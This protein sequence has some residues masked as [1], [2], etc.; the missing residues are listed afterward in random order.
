[1]N[2]E[3]LHSILQAVSDL[4]TQNGFTSAGKLLRVTDLR[5]AD[6][7]DTVTMIGAEVNTTRARAEEAIDA[8]TTKVAMLYPAGGSGPV[9]D[10]DM[11]ALMAATE[12]RDD[13]GTVLTVMSHLRSLAAGFHTM[14]SPGNGDELV[15]AVGKVEE[16]SKSLVRLLEI[17]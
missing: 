15:A 13:Y 16:A 10:Q 11:A 9:Y 14:Q 4:L 5:S 2:D 12:R 8:M 1:M 3:L 6:A 17:G 7:S